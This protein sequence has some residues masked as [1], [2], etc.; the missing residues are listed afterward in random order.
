[1]IVRGKINDLKDFFV[2]LPQ[3]QGKCVYFYR[4]NGYND[5][6][7]DFIGR[8]FTEASRCGTVIDGGIPNPD[9]K[10][11]LYYNEML[12]QAFRKDLYFISSS[13]KNWLPRLTPDQ[14]RTVTQALHDSLMKLEAE[15]KNEN[16]QKNA[17]IKF[18]C[19]LYYRFEPVV[20]KIGG[21]SVPKIL[22]EGSV[23]K[24]E[25]MMLSALCG[26]GC[27]IVM[28]GVKGDEAYRKSD[29]SAMYSD[30]LSLPGLSAFPQGYG[31]AYIRNAS[32]EKAA[33]SRLYGS[34]NIKNIGTNTWTEGKKPFEA[35]LTPAKDRGSGILNC[36][37]LVGGTEDKVSYAA[38]LYELRMSLLGQGRG[39]YIVSGS[40]PVPDNT[41]IQRIKRVNY[42]SFEQMIS[43]LT[44]NI[45]YITDRELRALIIK[46]FTEILRDEKSRDDN[47]NRLSST[48]VYILCWLK[49]VFPELYKGY[50]NGD[51]GCFIFLG[52]KCTK[53]EQLFYRFLSLTPTDVLL[54]DPD[55]G[56]PL[57]IADE[58]LL[59]TDHE[60]S[61]AVF[62]YPTDETGI[63]V[64]TA[65]FHAERELDSILYN[66]TGLY[67]NQQYSRA[68]AITLQTMYEEIPILWDQELKYRP[69]FSTENNMVS[70][71]VIFA[72]IMG[73]KDG[74]IGEYWK[75]VRQ[76]MTE[77]TYLIK[78]APHFTVPEP[79]PIRQHIAMFIQ[80]GKL[81]RREI[82]EDSGY[83]YGFLREEAQEHILDKIQLM[84]DGRLIKDQD[85][86]GRIYQ[87]LTVALSLNKD[88]IRLIQK[89]DF[90]KKNPKLIYINTGETEISLEDTTVVQ[91]L[92]LIGFDVIFFV[93]TGYR[94]VEKYFTALPFTEH[95]IGEY[96][97]DLNVPDIAPPRQSQKQSFFS[98]LFGKK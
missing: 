14:N 51:V 65:A 49:E 59:K 82:R 54:L 52:N 81:K 50:K 77:D 88:I 29:P 28:L 68:S 56:A 22:Y 62:E 53:N 44:A 94:C 72:K 79:S 42:T 91:L 38:K 80:N 60:E 15:G 61:M 85:E 64:G 23:T 89:F 2:P 25:L 36:F 58:R 11:L 9:Q 19:W 63:R 33:L 3:R 97:Y 8:Y 47:L 70:L 24:Y 86:G 7:G 30:E 66:D 34:T 12:G 37:Y 27:D 18:M 40:M 10:N 16:M 21:S 4:I 71:P 20:S 98:K 96:M 32:K 75:S 39:I 92:S 6:V 1:M 48:A 5:A 31:I 43:G 76:L 87:I 74:D 93:P 26:C 69:N 55:L 78:S 13:L 35:V 67:R 41:Q 45:S 17:Y 95:Q 83:N 73:V 84:L 90:T 57:T 46:A